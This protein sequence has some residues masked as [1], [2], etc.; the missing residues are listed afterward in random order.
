M[1]ISDANQIRNVVLV[2]HQGSG[3]TALSEAMLHT[4]GALSRTGSVTKGTTQSD[5]RESEK[6]R[7]MSIF[8]TLLHAEWDDKKINIL[9]TPGYP[10]FASEVIASMR[11]ADTALYVMDARS[12]VEVGTEMAWSY[13]EET[14]TPSLFVVNH[15]DHSNADFSSIVDEI[16]DRFG[17][18]ATVVQL[19]AGE[20]TRTVVDVLQM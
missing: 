17:R 10:D 16:E 18:G 4:S 15:I 20:G 14:E 1:T 5:H 12:G 2:G 8:A 3:K 19:P 7:Q 9:D 6:E 13:G 11:V